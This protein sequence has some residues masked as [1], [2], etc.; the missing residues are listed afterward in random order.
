MV[1]ASVYDI[2]QKRRLGK[3]ARSSDTTV[4]LPHVTVLIPAHNEETVIVRCLDSVFKSSYKS[5]DAMVINDASTDGTKQIL[6][7]Y[8]KLHPDY[9]LQYINKNVNVGKGAALN[10]ALRRYV[11]SELVMML[12]ADS[13]LSPRAIERAVSYFTDPLVV[14]VAANVQ[15]INEHT[16]LSVLQKFEHM[17]GYRSKKAYSITNSEFV[18]GGVASTYRMDVIRAVGFYDTDTTTEDISLSMKIVAMGNKQNRIVY[19]ADVM[20]MTEPVED[21]RALFRQRYRWKYGSLQNLFKHN[22]LIGKNDVR[23]SA[24]LTIYRLPMAVIT[25]VALFLLPLTWGY[26]L[27][28]TL[29]EKSLALVIGAYLTV[30]LYVFLTLWHDEHISFFERIYLSIYVPIIYFVFYIMDVIQILAMAHC[31]TKI[32]RLVRQDPAKSVWKSPVR[33]GGRVEFVPSVNGVD[34]RGRHD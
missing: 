6:K 19:G 29:L 3:L 5:F 15:I 4:K 31:L 11:R 24:M 17:I 22:E 25:E 12:D 32:R 33:I 34:S 10:S 18:V 16:T 30:T 23:Y 1:G 27:Y 13:V 2:W 14:G 7:L 20:A 8:K 28:L 21:I 26:A 9:D